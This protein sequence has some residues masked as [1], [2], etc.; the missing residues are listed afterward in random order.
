ML[1]HMAEEGLSVATDVGFVGNAWYCGMLMK[2]YD[3]CLDQYMNDPADP[4]I[5]S[6]QAY[7]D[8]CALKDKQQ[9]SITIF[10]HPCRLVST[11][12]WDVPLF[13]GTDLAIADIPP[14][15]LRSDEQIEQNKAVMEL[16]IQKINND[17]DF[18]WIDCAQHAHKHADTRRGL[19]NIM[20]ESGVSSIEEI[21]LRERGDESAYVG[22]AFQ[23]Y[24]PLYPEGFTGDRVLDQARRLLWTCNSL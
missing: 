6:Q 20:Q 21:P 19:T 15:P 17:S 4:G 2:S 10:S 23:R 16:I 12:F 24:W 1:L 11:A 22:K 3:L 13:K 18:N 8:I 9:S 14:A 5:L 7:R